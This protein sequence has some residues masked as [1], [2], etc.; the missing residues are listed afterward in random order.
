MKLLL[1]M[2]A[3]IPIIIFTLLQSCMLEIEHINYDHTRK[4]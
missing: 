1:V 4:K 3:T 2:I